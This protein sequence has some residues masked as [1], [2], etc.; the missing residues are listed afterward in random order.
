[1]VQNRALFALPAD[2][3]AAET[4]AFRGNGRT[5][6]SRP[7]A[8][9]SCYISKLLNQTTFFCPPQ[10]RPSFSVVGKPCR[11]RVFPGGPWRQPPVHRVV[12]QLLPT[13]P[14]LKRFRSRRVSDRASTTVRTHRLA[15]SARR[16]KT[17]AAKPR[18]AAPS[19]HKPMRGRAMQ[20]GEHRVR[21]RRTHARLARLHPIGLCR[22]GRA[23]LFGAAED[24]KAGGPPR[25]RSNRTAALRLSPGCRTRGR[26][27]R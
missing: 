5:S 13:P 24:P 1:L 22:V 12:P 7:P 6:L 23:K 26:A 17:I 27:P 3:A 18:P 14:P 15:A 16:R 4:S 20:R 25:I 2:H 21:N 10:T 19:R 8:E 11:M 9:R